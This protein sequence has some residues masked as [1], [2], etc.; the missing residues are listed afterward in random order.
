MNKS[1]IYECFYHNSLLLH[2]YLNNQGTQSCMIKHNIL[3]HHLYIQNRHRRHILQSHLSV[4]SLLFQDLQDIRP[5][6]FFQAF[7]VLYRP[8]AFHGCPKHSKQTRNSP[9]CSMRC[10]YLQ[11]PEYSQT[12]IMFSCFSIVGSSSCFILISEIL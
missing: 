4:F 12:Q 1:H 5:P 11:P 8:R 7:Q 6:F 2:L 10:L 9:R 3:F